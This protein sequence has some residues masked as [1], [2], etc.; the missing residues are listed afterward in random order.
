MPRNIYFKKECKLK[1]FPDTLKLKEFITRRLT[2]QK[3]KRKSFRQGN[4][5]TE[6]DEGLVRGMKSTRS[7]KP[8]SK[9]IVVNI[10]LFI[11]YTGIKI[12][13]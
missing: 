11:N 7:G 8:L 5:G 12:K 9:L 3:S 2:P 10:T 1:A 13:K 4:R 6:R